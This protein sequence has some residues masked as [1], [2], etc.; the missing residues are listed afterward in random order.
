MLTSAT[1]PDTTDLNL[2]VFLQWSLESAVRLCREIR[3]SPLMSA[4]T[5][6]FYEFGEFRLDPDARVLYRESTRVSLTPKVFDTLQFFVEHAGRLLEKDEL[7]RTIW[8]D[9]FVEESNL[10]FNIKMLRKALHDDAHQPRFIETVPRRGYRFIAEVRE[11]TTAITESNSLGPATV[12]LFR[13]RSYLL[14]AG[15]LVL[16]AGSVV[17]ASRFVRGRHSASAPSA[18]ILSAPFKSEKLT[19][20]GSVHAVISPNGKY[21]AYTSNSGGKESIWLRQLDTSENIQIVPPTNGY[22]LGL[23]IS[24]DGNSLYFVRE[25]QTYPSSAIYRVMT[26]G[27]IPVRIAEK[28]EGWIS[29][30]PDDKQISFVRCA[31]R[32]NDYCSLMTI[33]ADGRNERQLLVRQRPIRITG[34]Q[35]SPDGQ[36]IAFAAGQSSNGAKDFRLR[37]LDLATGAESEITQM[38]FFEIRDLKWLPDGAGLL[39]TGK[40][41]LDGKLRIWQV[42]AA[43]GEV[44]A[45]TKDAFNYIG[46]S[47]DKGA[48]KM[49]ATHVSDTFHL[50]LSTAGDLNSPRVLTAARSFTFTPDGRIV[51]SGD[52]GDIWSINR[53]GGEQR[54]LTNSPFADFSPRVSTEG[55]YIFFASNR[56]GSNQ[57]WRMNADGSNQVQLTKTE[58]GYPRFATP[59]GQWLYFESGL[60]QTLWRVSTRGGDEIPIAVG[61]VYSLAFSADGKLAAYFSRAESDNHVR[62]GVLSV[63]DRKVV[64]TFDLGDEIPIKIAWG[65]D[66]QTLQYITTNGSRSFLWRRSLDNEKPHLIADLGDDVIGDFAL[67]PDGSSV[68]LIRG[69]WLHDAVLIEGLQ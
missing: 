65:T 52:D 62:I 36:S 23:A 14:I 13:R 33:D 10:T 69:K 49:I 27:G 60:H 24:N 5:G 32:E 21:A 48:D 64:T 1:Y 43:T 54:Q 20:T 67:S 31:Y 38:A 68:A 18:P 29:V 44:N 37:R 17:V 61:R 47:L 39:L 53:D 45:L 46:I 8:Q 41:M 57:V 7:M 34:N 59:D 2:N 40:E 42:S 4:E 51:Y 58:G 15:V 26:F 56:S 16:V 50:Y 12:P 28:A 25:N 19:N 30:S 22:Y 6:H 63:A 55:R 11:R 66:N 9:R 3:E 35:F